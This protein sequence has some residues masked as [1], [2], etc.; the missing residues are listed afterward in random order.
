MQNNR[1]FGNLE[2]IQGFYPGQECLRQRLKH[3]F[4]SQLICPVMYVR[5]QLGFHLHFLLIPHHAGQVDP[6]LQKL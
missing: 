5:N 6:S 3:L 2:Y 4:E 1:K